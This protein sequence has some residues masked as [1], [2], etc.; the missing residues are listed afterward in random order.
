[1]RVRSQELTNV[2]TSM[3]TYVGL[4]EEYIRVALLTL[5]SIA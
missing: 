5:S 4:S 2:S 1:M 3:D